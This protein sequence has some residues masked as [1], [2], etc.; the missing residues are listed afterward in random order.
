[1]RPAFIIPYRLRLRHA[2]LQLLHQLESLLSLVS[3]LTAVGGE[4]VI[5]S[6]PKS[7]VVVGR[8]NGPSNSQLSLNLA[9]LLIEHC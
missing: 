7:Q 6:V 1:M 2:V 5:H 3:K 9:L 4:M 8:N